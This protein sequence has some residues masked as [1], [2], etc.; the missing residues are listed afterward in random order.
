VKIKSQYQLALLAA[1]LLLP[2]MISNE[3]FWMDECGT[4]VYGQQPSLSA[5]WHHLVTDNGDCQMPASL[6]FAWIVSHVF[7][8]HEWQ[9]RETNILWGALALV[10]MYRAGKRLQLPWLPLLLAIQPYFWFYTNEARAYALELS[11]GA[12]LFAGLTAFLCSQAE[13]DSWAWE[14]SLGAVGLCYAT[15][16]APAAIMTTLVAGGIIALKNKWKIHRK[17]LAILS[18]SAIAALPSGIYYGSTLAR[19]AAETKLWHVDLKFFAYVIYEITGL[20]GLGPPLDNIREL[21]RSPHVGAAVMNHISQFALPAICGALLLLVLILGLRKWS[22][23]FK[24]PVVVGI[25]LVLIASSLLFVVVGIAVQKA[26]WGRHF[27]PFVPFYVALLGI[28]MAGSQA[29]R[30]LRWLTFLLAGLLA[31]SSLNLRFGAEHR[32]ENYRA[33]AEIARSALAEKKSV[34][35]AAAIAGAQY[36]HLDYSTESPESGKAFCT[37]F[38]DVTKYAPPDVIVFSRPDVFGANGALEKIIRENGYRPIQ[39]LNGFVIWSK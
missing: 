39:T 11:C 13:D 10:A 22:P 28:A 30:K 32:K 8:S 31:L 38:A 27:A 19:G 21:A 1:L 4:A 5:W 35:W 6:L 15:M 24:K 36:Y 16:L 18:G 7:G 17:A 25:A 37:F 14:F 23:Q 12:W 26:F 2:L 33:A 29:S 9:L 34:W 3:S 20:V